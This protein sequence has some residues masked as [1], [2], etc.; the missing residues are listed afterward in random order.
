MGAAV[1]AATTIGEAVKAPTAATEA[2]EIIGV[3]ATPEAAI[4]GGVGVGRS[5]ATL[6]AFLARFL[7][8]RGVN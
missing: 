4:V 7:Q 8:E 5:F 1:G 2:T 3:V 6:L